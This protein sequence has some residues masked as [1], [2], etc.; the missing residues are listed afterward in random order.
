MQE[1]WVRKA[2]LADIPVLLEFEQGVI[3][4]ERPFDSTLKPG[5]IHY[6]DL[7]KLIGS[8]ESVVLVALKD[9]E[10][11]ASGYAWVKPAK[12]YLNHTQYGYLGFMYVKPEYRGQGIICHILEGL[13]N[14]CLERQIHE[15]SLDVYC[16]NLPAITAYQKAGFKKHLMEMRMNLKPE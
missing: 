7:E 8:D 2:T 4:A 12:P 5:M 6:Y 1:I 14:W 10:I 15:V 13:K 9:R 16:A 3:L 11:V